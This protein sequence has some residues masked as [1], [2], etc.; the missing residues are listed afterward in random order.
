MPFVARLASFGDRAAL[1]TPTEVISYAEL[2][3]RVDEV[4]ATLGATRRLV[5]VAG[6]TDVEP[7]VAY[8]AALSAGHPVILVPGDNPRSL[9][10]VE[11]A[12]DPD[13]VFTDGTMVE[14]REGTVHDLHPSLAL[15]LS[16]SGSTGSPKLV[17]LSRDNIE[18]NA[19]SI[20]SYLGIRPTDVAATTLPVHYC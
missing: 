3:R 6:S 5:L 17:R 20:A 8:L 2:A 11:A 18:A 4:A 14:R 13:V 10:S 16:T 19:A 7:I 15:L 1:V 12:Y 9:A